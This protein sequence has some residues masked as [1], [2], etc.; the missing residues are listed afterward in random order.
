M[1]TGQK[2]LFL[3]NFDAEFVGFSTKAGFGY[4][5]GVLAGRQ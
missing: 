2:S 1:K 5:N 4:G 3:A